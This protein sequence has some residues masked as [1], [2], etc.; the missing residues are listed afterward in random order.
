M[1]QRR[2]ACFTCLVSVGLSAST[3]KRHEPAVEMEGLDFRMSG[4]LSSASR[5]KRQSTETQYHI[6]VML[7]VDQ[8]MFK[9][10]KFKS[11]E[12]AQEYAMTLANLVSTTNAQ[13]SKVRGRKLFI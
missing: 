10:R 2:S 11:V 4:V 8:E 9:K 1:C 7:V 5:K 6:E 12:E 3:A 13:K